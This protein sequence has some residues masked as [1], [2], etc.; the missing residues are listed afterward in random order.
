MQG[1]NVTADHI[2]MH[3]AFL[4]NYIRYICH[5]NIM[6]NKIMCIV[7]CDC[8]HIHIILTKKTNKYNVF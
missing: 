5:A 4:I 6:K 2:H 1:N 7:L 8:V 3:E